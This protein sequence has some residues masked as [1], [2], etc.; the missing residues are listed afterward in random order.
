MNRVVRLIY[1][2]DPVAGPAID[3]YREVP[4]GPVILGGLKD[5]KLLQFY[6]EA[7]DTLNI[8][9][10][11][12][13]LAGDILVEGRLIVHLL[14]SE[15]RGYWKEMIVHDSDYVLVEP[16][17]IIGEEP[18]IDLMV[19]PS[20]QRWAVNP[21]PRIVAQRKKLDPKLVQLMAAGATIP[22]SPE[23]TIFVPR[24][25]SAHDVMGT[26]LLMRILPVIAV[27]W[28]YLQAEVTG[29][30]RRAAPWTIAKVGIEDKWEPS[31]EEMMAIQDMMVAAEEDPT[32]AKLVFRNGVELESTSAHHTELAKWI[33]QWSIF[34][35]AKLQGLGMN[36]AFA[37]GEAS[38]SYLESMLSLGME[39]IRNFR[40]FIAV[41]VLREGLLAPLARLHGYYKRSRAELDHNI[42]T[43]PKHEGNLAIPTVEWS[44]SL[45]PTADRDYLDILEMLEGKGMP[46]PL[47][48][49]AQAGGY[50]LEEALDGMQGDL[51]L[52]KKLA[53]YNKQVKAISGDDEEDEGSRWGSFQLRSG[54]V[55]AAVAELPVWANKDEFL[56]LRRGEVSRLSEYVEGLKVNGKKPGIREWK[57]VEA[58]MKDDGIHYDKI[59]SFRYMLS[60]AGV[61]DAPLPNKTVVKVRDAI[62]RRNNGRTPD[63]AM[64]K[65]VYWLNHEMER[66]EIEPEQVSARVL[67]NTSAAP[68]VRP[69]TSRLLTGEGYVEEG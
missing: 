48:K 36:E 17:P 16:S 1:L 19:P 64:M 2:T 69:A 63:R 40:Q 38:W 25:A 30:R 32:G 37:T 9:R 42:R 23:N 11:L 10:H 41:E 7:L 44:R 4:F 67:S 5:E 18:T 43:T 13:F 8:Q 47:R 45:Q 27:E 35:E 60:R 66:R 46:I 15:S 49:W 57:Q 31:P 62:L 20:Y 61:I 68:W 3:F 24:R 33:E 51:A 12:P 54:S 22:L 55:A 59:R 28:A 65:E 29:L 21:D 52:R 26:S 6:N 50:D 34:K 56:K 58:R 14:L 53:A 39:R